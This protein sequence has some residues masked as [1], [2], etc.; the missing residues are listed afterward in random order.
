M[1]HTMLHMLY[2]VVCSL[3]T[4]L[5]HKRSHGTDKLARQCHTLLLHLQKIAIKVFRFSPQI[6][7]VSILSRNSRLPLLPLLPILHDFFFFLSFLISFSFCSAESTPSF[8]FQ[9]DHQKLRCCP[10]FRRKL[11]LSS[12]ACLLFLPQTHGSMWQCHGSPRQRQFH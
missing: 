6:L 5:T 3:F 4:V 1:F 2:F 8:P 7:K 12:N 9:T 10:V 11:G